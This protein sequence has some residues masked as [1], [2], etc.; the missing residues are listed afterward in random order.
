MR[1]KNITDRAIRVAKY[2]WIKPGDTF[3]VPVEDA[4][5]NGNLAS[6]AEFEAVKATKKA[7]TPTP[8]TTRTKS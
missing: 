8:T 1:F 6:M 3:E 5:A 7:T 2:G 4:D